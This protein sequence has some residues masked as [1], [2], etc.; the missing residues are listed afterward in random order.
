[1]LA[2]GT[3]IL[4]FVGLA[5]K[6]IAWEIHHPAGAMPAKIR[7][8]NIDGDVIEDPE[9]TPL[10][11]GDVVQMGTHCYTFSSTARQPSTWSDKICETEESKG[12]LNDEE[13]AARI[14]SIDICGITFEENPDALVPA[15]KLLIEDP[16]KE[17][18]LAVK[19]AL[20][21]YKIRMK[22]WSELK[23]KIAKKK[24]TPGKKLAGSAGREAKDESKREATALKRQDDTLHNMGIDFQDYF[25]DY[26]G[27]LEAHGMYDE[28]YYQSIVAKWKRILENAKKSYKYG[29]VDS[30]SL[31]LV[32]QYYYDEEVE[33]EREELAL[34]RL[35]RERA[36]ASLPR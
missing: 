36:R 18:E 26:K 29:S 6:C 32:D 1:M 19:A 17:I 7:K 31:E 12:V 22:K 16:C 14:T 13:F 21:D 10:Q 30:A 15:I 4:I 24:R 2:F 11:I 28:D 23:K 5:V 25:R 20:D 8:V 34:K 3:H 33:A 9:M 35:E 27:L